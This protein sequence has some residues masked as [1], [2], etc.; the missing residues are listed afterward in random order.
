MTE[1]D[2]RRVS[3]LISDEDRWPALSRVAR[4]RD[5]SVLLMLSGGIPAVSYHPSL[6]G[7]EKIVVMLGYAKAL[8]AVAR[9]MVEVGMTN[10]VARSSWNFDTLDIDA[11]RV[12][13]QHITKTVSLAEEQGVDDGEGID[14]ARFTRDVFHEILSLAEGCLASGKRPE[15]EN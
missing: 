14:T 15:E 12:A 9:L 4:E 8:T 1:N 11:M 2:E 6:D 7:Q 5:Q 10:G 3:V 13:C